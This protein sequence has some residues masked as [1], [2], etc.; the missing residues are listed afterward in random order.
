[1]VR[2]GIECTLLGS[3]W[4]AKYGPEHR[5]SYEGGGWATNG[6]RPGWTGLTAERASSSSIIYILSLSPPCAPYGPYSGFS[7]AL[8]M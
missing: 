3:P 2:R 6:S 4:R 8:H 7:S 1:M 5:G